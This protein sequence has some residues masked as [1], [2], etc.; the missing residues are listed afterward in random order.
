MT[1]IIE[2][3][4]LAEFV[5]VDG[6]SARR[7]IFLVRRNVDQPHLKDFGLT[8]EEGKT[9][10]DTV[11]RRRM[12]RLQIDCRL[13]WLDEQRQSRSACRRSSVRGFHSAKPAGFSIFSCPPPALTI[14]KAFEIGSH[15]LQIRSRQK[16]W[17]TRIA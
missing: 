17:R 1:G 11:R 2:L 10:S 7:E 14:T 15:G 6:I 5:G 4:I 9:I 12:R 13:C 8:L 3:T 16:I